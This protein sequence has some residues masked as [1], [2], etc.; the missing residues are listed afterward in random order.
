[1]NMPSFPILHGWMGE[2]IQDDVMEKISALYI[3]EN[4][5]V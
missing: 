2:L 4:D 1:M 3:I 5:R